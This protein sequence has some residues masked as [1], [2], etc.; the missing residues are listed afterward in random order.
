MVPI[1]EAIVEKLR[2]D[3]PCSLDDVVTHLSRFSSEEIFITID[4]MAS[5]GRVFLHQR[6]YSTYHLSLNSHVAPP[7]SRRVA[8]GERTTQSLER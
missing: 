6:G 2:N 7:V 5:D 8:E 3:G 1:E 4:R